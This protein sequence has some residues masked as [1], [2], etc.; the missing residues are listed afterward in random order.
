[1]QG[2]LLSTQP[3]AVNHTEKKTRQLLYY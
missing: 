1:M 2:S 3:S